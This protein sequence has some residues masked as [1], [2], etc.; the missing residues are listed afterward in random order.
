MTCHFLALL[1]QALMELEV[2]RA[3][4]SRGI[5]ALVL[6][7]EERP[8]SS[9][10]AARIVGVFTGVARHQLFD[11]T[12]AL[13]QTFA[14]VLPPLQEQLLDLLGVPLSTSTADQASRGEKTASRSAE[15]GFKLGSPHIKQT[16]IMTTT[17][18]YHT[19]G[20]KKYSL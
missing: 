18:P 10:S 9:P 4:A 15:R 5:D 8:S 3:M 17:G 7:P 12:G 19:H 11:A 20:L 14:P 16:Q 1:L 6:Y 2:R 13:V